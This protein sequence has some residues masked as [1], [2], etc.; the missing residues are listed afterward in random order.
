MKL[1]SPILDR[2]LS[3]KWR[4][5][6][7]QISTI[8]QSDNYG[9]L[10]NPSYCED[11]LIT[12]HLCQFM[13]DEKFKK[14]YAL[15]KGTG[16][17]RTHPT[18]IHWRVY[19]ACWAAN[20]AKYLEGDFV[21]CG[22]SLGLISRAVVDYVHFNT[23]QKKFYLFDTY[24]GIPDGVLNDKEKAL[25]ISN[26]LFDYQD[27]YTLVQKE[28]A[29]IPNVKVVRGI[30]PES[31]T[32]EPIQKVAYLSIDMNNAASEIAAIDFFWDKLV[33]GGIVV[34]DDYSYSVQFME[35]HTA[36]DKFCT[37]HNVRVLELPT[38]QGLIFKPLCI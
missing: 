30:V 36:F 28:F 17:L 18:D 3:K 19:V 38:G 29:D 6:V 16:A 26:T 20:W 25:G 21:E 9:F 10:I 8:L 12:F 24:A 14:A 35:Q 23:L 5:K 37:Q 11:G 34:L 13:Q 27:C 15:G 31:L 7:S 2:V 32:H 33:P 4:V 22:V 1:L